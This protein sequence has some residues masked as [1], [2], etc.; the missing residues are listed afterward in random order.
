M[1]IRKAIEEMKKGKKV[2][3]KLA[4]EGYH[5]WEDNTV[6]FYSFDGG[7]KLDIFT[8]NKDAL[9]DVILSDDFEILVENDVI[10]EDGE[11]R[12]GTALINLELGN[13][14]A[15]K[16]WFKKEM[17]LT[18]QVPDKYSKMTEK[19]IYITIGEDYRIPWTPSQADMLGK[20]WYIV[21]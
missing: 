14:V 1:N 21:R 11:F 18:L 17:Y 19:Y 13:K 8:S 20:D 9:L 2:T 10:D 12:F 7:L 4:P 3:H 16:G 15:R 6:M 5:I